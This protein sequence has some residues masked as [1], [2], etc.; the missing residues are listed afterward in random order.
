MDQAENALNRPAQNYAPG[1]GLARNDHFQIAFNTNDM[2]KAVALFAARYGI[3]EF[4]QLAGPTASGGKIRMEIGWAG[5]V[6]YELIWGEGPG[7]EVFRVGLPESGFAIRP[8]HLG[9]HV[10]TQA[11]WDAVLAE[12]ERGGQ[13]IVHQTHVPGFLRAIIV[14]QPELGIFLEYIF[15]E[16][17]GIQFFETAPSN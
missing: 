15:P 4:R 16:A 14:E 2:D 12:L 1:D 3:K 17:G 8:H 6:M 10:P 7:T 5:G 9:Y 11:G 13:K